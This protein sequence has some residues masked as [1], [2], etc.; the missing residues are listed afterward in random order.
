M[1][2]V[3]NTIQKHKVEVSLHLL[4]TVKFRVT[5][6][7]SWE[8]RYLSGFLVDVVKTLFQLCPIEL[9]ATRKCN[10]ASTVAASYMWLLSI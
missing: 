4:S 5:G 2:T 3:E 8:L 1:L 10:L 7:D 9:S 6:K